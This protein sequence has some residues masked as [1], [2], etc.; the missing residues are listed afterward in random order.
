[1][2][3]AIQCST[4]K[5]GGGAGEG[6]PPRKRWL[7]FSDDNGIWQ[8]SICQTKA[9]SSS[10]PSRARAGVKDRKTKHPSS[11][12]VAFFAIRHSPFAIAPQSVRCHAHMSIVKCRPAAAAP[13]AAD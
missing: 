9:T 6:N 3:H 8:L 12:Q 13:L 2:A 5:G 10:S 1:M 7:P 11:A 4:A